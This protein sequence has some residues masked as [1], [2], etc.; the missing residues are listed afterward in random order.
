MKIIEQI[1]TIDPSAKDALFRRLMADESLG[2]L[3]GEDD[4]GTITGFEISHTESNRLAG[5]A[6]I[7]M[8]K[9]TILAYK[10]DLDEEPKLILFPDMNKMQ[11]PSFKLLSV[12][13][14]RK[15]FK[16]DT[17]TGKTLVEG[18]LHEVAKDLIPPYKRVEI[19]DE[20]AASMNDAMIETN[21]DGRKQSRP[22][23]KAPEGPFGARTSAPTQSAPAQ[24]N[25]PDDVPM[26]IPM[27][28]PMDV[29]MDAPVDFEP[30]YDPGFD[31]TPMEYGGFDSYEGEPTPE[32]EPPKD[33]KI[34]PKTPK[35]I[36]LHNQTFK[37]I[38]E[39]SDYVVLYQ[40]VPADFASNVIT[41]ALQSTPDAKTQID[42]A[43]L[44]FVKLF[45]ADKL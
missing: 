35:A 4:A 36:E 15:V 22:T 37:A 26:D 6:V 44:L 12:V 31:D 14:K 34:I 10:S 45:N 5:Y 24:S 25:I 33:N 29:P 1:S 30:D 23:P 41:A 20:M 43:V 16:D 9:H 2:F 27:D 11:D 13:V 42:V 38:S 39:V 28:V 7:A 40:N 3:R 17:F 21:F 32:P 19:S 18:P 8:Q